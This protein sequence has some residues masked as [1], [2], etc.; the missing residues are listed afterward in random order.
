MS[1]EGEK[2]L[3]QIDRLITKAGLT[4]GDSE[5][6]YDFQR[7]NI[8]IDRIRVLGIIS[9]LVKADS[10]IELKLKEFLNSP[11]FTEKV[12]QI[13]GSNSIEEDFE[14]AFKQ[15]IQGKKVKLPKHTPKPA[16][17]K[18]VRD[19]RGRFASL[20]NLKLLINEKLHDR[21]QA[22]MGKG[23]AKS[24]LNYRTGRFA[25]KFNNSAEVTGLTS[26]RD[27]TVTAF[28]TYMKYPYQTF[29]PGFKQG[30]PTSRDPRLLISKSIR[31][32]ASTLIRNRLRTIPV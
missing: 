15:T 8:D 24:I 27:G 22:N 21:I 3:I 2:L 20:V 7:P 17:K 13:K 25:G 29:E 26:D 11:A 18:T 31:Q 1:I 19:I 14:E 4:Q 32:I 28:Y 16:E 9:L 5:I 12:I 23:S 10:G 6:T 30:E